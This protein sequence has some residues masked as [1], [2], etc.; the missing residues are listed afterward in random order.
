M[1]LADDVAIQDTHSTKPKALSLVLDGRDQGPLHCHDLLAATSHAR[2][3]G[4]RP[5]ARHPAFFGPSFMIALQFRAARMA[6][7]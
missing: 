7:R 5:A 4:G 6:A 3:P 1:E 2:N